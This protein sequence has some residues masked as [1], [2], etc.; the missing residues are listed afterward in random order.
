MNWIR[1]DTISAVME[2]GVA[3]LQR[4]QDASLRRWHLSWDLQDDSDLGMLESIHCGIVDNRTAGNA[5]VCHRALV[6]AT[7]CSHTVASAAA[8]RNGATALHF[9]LQKELHTVLQ[10]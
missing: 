8:V 4:V 9:L 6:K 10:S 5:L 3:M 2:V 7:R 1:T